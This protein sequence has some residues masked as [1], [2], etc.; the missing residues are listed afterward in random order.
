MAFACYLTIEG[1]QQGTFHGEQSF[2]KFGSGKITAVK[3]S[4]GV[5]TPHDVATG[6][7]SGKRQHQ[8]I[9]FTKEWGAATPQL[10]TALV[11]NE[12][13][14][15]VVF[16]F[17]RTSADGKEQVTLVV[18]L[19]NASVVSIASALNLVDRHQ[20][21]FDGHELE[22]IELTFEKIQIEEKASNQTASD[23]WEAAS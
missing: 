15:S 5:T 9:K 14:T 3:F 20:S 17:T 22:D 4:S 19:T 18:T 12:K 11:T 2:S 8:T 13:L 7:A 10:F 21:A 23:D 1:A 16:N 6:Q